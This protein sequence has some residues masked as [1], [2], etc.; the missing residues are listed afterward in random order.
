[1][2]GEYVIPQILGYGQT[3]LMGNAL[4]TDFLEANDNWF[5]AIEERAEKVRQ[6]FKLPQR[7]TSDVLVDV[8]RKTGVDVELVQPDDTSSVVRRWDPEVPRLT[9]TSSMFEQ[10]LKFQL[11]HTIGLWLMDQESLH[12]RITASLSTC[13]ATC[14]NKSLTGMPLSPYC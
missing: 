10:R 2:M 12:D 9:L 5:G 4:V 14:G 11:A 3:Y 1:M 8:L 7:Y 6:D 13:R